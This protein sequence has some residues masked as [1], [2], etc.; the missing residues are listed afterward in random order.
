MVQACWRGLAQTVAIWYYEAVYIDP[1][2]TR[3]DY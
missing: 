2:T 3:F 1:H